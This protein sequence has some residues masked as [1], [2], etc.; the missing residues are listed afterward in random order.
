MEI[1]EYWINIQKEMLKQIIK[2]YK[3]N[4]KKFNKYKINFDKFVKLSNELIFL[5][6]EVFDDSTRPEPYVYWSPDD[7]ELCVYSEIKDSVNII[8]NTN[9]LFI[10]TIFDEINSIFKTR[11]QSNFQ[12]IWR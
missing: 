5:Y 12:K 3:K 8:K 6:R 1:D 7:L 2:E 9:D 11:I 4:I 10:E